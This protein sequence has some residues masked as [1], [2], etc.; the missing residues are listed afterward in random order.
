MLEATTK[1]E[2]RNLHWASTLPGGNELEDDVKGLRVALI[3][4]LIFCERR[5][6]EEVAERE[7]AVW[8]DN[9]LVNETLSGV[10]QLIEQAREVS[11]N[12]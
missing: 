1:G 4:H 6:L 3:A 10:A 9:D 11:E 7:G 2:A 12:V 8:V 5:R